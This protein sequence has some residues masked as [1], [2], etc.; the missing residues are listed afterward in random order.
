LTLTPTP[1]TRARPPIGVWLVA[2]TPLDATYPCRCATTKRC[3]PSYCSCLGRTDIETMPDVCCAK[4]FIET[5]ERG[6]RGSAV[7]SA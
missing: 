5:K 7:D 1:D 3:N 6:A 2:G 4:R